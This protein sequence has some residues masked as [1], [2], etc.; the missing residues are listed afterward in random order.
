MASPDGKFHK[1]A[2]QVVEH[3]I[4]NYIDSAAMW[5]TD[6]VKQKVKDDEEEGRTFTCMAAGTMLAFSFEAYLNAIGGRKLPLWNEWDDYHTKIDKV[7]QHLKITPDWS[8][9]P[10]SSVSAMKRL[11]NF[12]AHGKPETTDKKKEFIDKAEG[13]KGKELDMKAEWQTLCTPDMVINA[14]EDLTKVWDDMIEKSG[15]HPYDLTTKGELTVTIGEKFVPQ[16]KMGNAKP[17]ATKPAMPS[18]R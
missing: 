17:A 6:I 4:H 3:N 5:F 7:F 9:R 1:E 16:A 18:A 12:L 2:H 11:R 8:K 10:Y 14:Y 15:I 13:N